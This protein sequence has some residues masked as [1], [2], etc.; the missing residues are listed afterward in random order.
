MKSPAFRTPKPQRDTVC[1][2]H[3]D[4]R[5]HHTGAADLHEYRT[6]GRVDRQPVQ[7]VEEQARDEEQRERARLHVRAHGL[8]RSLRSAGHA[9]PEIV[10][11]RYRSALL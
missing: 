5:A 8:H 7:Y 3:V 1:A 2:Q 9:V 11:V 4:A 10:Q 6:C